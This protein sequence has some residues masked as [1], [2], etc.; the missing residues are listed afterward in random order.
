MA[1][2]IV[3][4]ILTYADEFHRCG[5]RQWEKGVRKVIEAYPKAAYVGLSATHIRYLDNQRD[6]ANELF[7]DSIASHMSLT[8]A[9]A[10]GILPTPKYVVSLF[11]Y[12]DAI[13][14]Y[15]K[16]ADRIK[17]K[18]VRK[19][20]LEVINEIKH[21]LSLS[22]GLDQVFKRYMPNGHGKYLI[23]C[24]GIKHMNEMISLYNKWFGWADKEPHIYKV[25]C[26]QQ[27]TMAEFNAFKNDNSDHMRLLYVVDILNEGIHINNIDGVIMLRITS[28]P[29]IYS[30][31]VGR[32]LSAGGKREP[33]IFDVV[34]NYDSLVSIKDMWNEE[35][36]AREYEYIGGGDKL[37]IKEP[38]Q[39][40]DD[41]C[42]SRELFCY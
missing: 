23:F 31:Q 6:M 22:E 19:E 37:L 9:I 33:L 25:Y 15:E 17:N 35:V 26:E 32:A 29:I 10:R 36:Y 40:I 39:I 3:R 20:S 4:P 1:E 28:S 14:Q 24:S 7:E 12:K 38:F 27:N 42:E 5:A 2:K 34:N 41:T 8:E 21:S 30:Q 18:V 16:R 11:S 13:V